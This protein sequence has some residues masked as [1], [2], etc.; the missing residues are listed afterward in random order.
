[1]KARQE[2]KESN[3]KEGNQLTDDKKQKPRKE[4]RR[5]NMGAAI[6]YTDHNTTE[7][8]L[9]EIPQQVPIIPLRN[10]VVFPGVLLP[11]FVGR[12]NSVKLIEKCGKPGALVGLFTQKS[13]EDEEISL[14]K[15]YSTGT[16]AEIHQLAPM[17][18]EGYQILLHGVQKIELLNIVQKQPYLSG[19]VAGVGEINDITEKEYLEFQQ[20]II[21]FVEAHPNIPNEIVTFVR[22]LENPSSLVNHHLFFSQRSVEERI[23]FLRMSS[24]SEKV[25]ILTKELIEETNQL[26]MER[27]VRKKVEEDASRMQKEF[28]LR[29]QLETIRKELGEN[30]D[31]SD[32]LEK[33]LKEKKLPDYMRK[34]AK[35]ELRRI[36]QL[37]EG[38]P[39][40]GLEVGQIRS[41]LELVLELPWE[42]PKKQEISLRKAAQILNED[43]EGLE[44]VKERI[45]EFLAVEK[46]TGGSRAPILCLVGPPG[47]GKTSLAGSIAR[48]L[49]RP[50]VRTSLGGVRDEAEIRGHRRTYVGAMPGK[51]LQAMKKSQKRNPVFLLDEID[52]TGISYQG[53]PSAALLEVLDPE[54][55]NSFEDHYLGEP[56]DLSQVLFVC[57]ANNLDTISTPLQDRMEIVHLSGYTL[58]E[59]KAIATK[60]LL[61][62]II[63]KMKFQQG[64]LQLSDEAL[65]K[66]IVSHTREAGVRSLK[67][68]LESLAHKAVRTLIERREARQEDKQGDKQEGK[69]EENRG[70]EKKEDLVY[71]IEEVKE[72]LGRDRYY[73]DYKENT[74]IPGVAMGLAWTPVGGDI[75]FV[76]AT[77]YKGKGE[78]KLSGRLGDVM[79]ESAQAALSF[80]RAHSREMHLKPQVFEN[81]D[82]HIH[83]PSGAIPKDGPSAGVTLL[84]ALASLFTKKAVASDIAMT[85]EISL[86][87]RILPVGGIKEKVLAA[88]AA[89]INMVLLPEKNR[90]EYEEMPEKLREGIEVEYYD[91]MLSLLRRS[92]PEA[93]ATTD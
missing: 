65:I 21:R 17:G 87:G 45:L 48:A 53:D 59:K 13:P 49:G 28:Y 31:D 43:H 75:L 76:E 60:H 77:S 92:V 66:V 19:R 69:K 38:S 68:R 46:Q 37:Q 12:N 26:L 15:L 71:G 55:N 10:A 6:R 1:M 5:F 88:Q 54:Q 4:A 61:P 62:E 57:T 78:L 9:S 11:I 89:G 67:R 81:Y 23:K 18:D 58:A 35:K 51:V 80:L 32:D 36:K 63:E 85:G 86:R 27:E 7:I 34:R 8:E 84:S 79:K 47:V 70:V 39:G 93:F 2:K 50:F 30:E 82:V 72:Y 73:M 3:Q 22:R 16:L 25:Q 14:K 91:D 74:N 90:S 29:K 20:R 41:W 83:I 40:G 24:I 56:Y 33:Q 64:Q 42:K 44:D 52:K